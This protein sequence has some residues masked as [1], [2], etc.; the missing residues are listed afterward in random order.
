MQ[1]PHTHPAE[2]ATSGW[3][4]ARS[5]A[6]AAPARFPLEG[7]DAYGR[8]RDARLAAW[9]VDMEA[10]RVP[11]ADPGRLRDPE[12]RALARRCATF[13]MAIYAADP[14]ADLSRRD[15]L[16]LGRRLGLTAVDRGP[17]GTTD[18]VAAIRV[19][20]GAPAGEYIPYTARALNWHTDG[21]YNSLDR[22]VRGF[23]MHCARQAGSGGA[24]R[25]LD[26]EIAYILLRDRDPAYAEALMA[27]D[28]M[29]IPANTDPDRA[30]RPARIG[31]VFSVDPGS[32]RLHM[33][34]TA[35]QRSIRWK[36]G[37]AAEAAECLR[38]LIEG[39][40]P[41]VVH[42]R[43]EP[44]Q[45][46]VCNNVLHAR[47]AFDDGEGDGRLLWRIRYHQR[48]TEAGEDGPC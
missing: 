11:I 29:T 41:Y 12:R 17:D 7:G 32:G 42:V 6:V 35:R 48:I 28:A 34:Y 10:L 33:R 30:P 15:L 22:P 39:A 45:G 1:N 2:P 13:N 14:G 27:A 25:F 4:T 31:P 37:A 47:T 38:E 23:V 26:H 3:N 8:W 16:A 44:G 46:V 9:A 5:A 21:Y 40:S 20:G 24:S 18:G 19:T 43:L 36:P